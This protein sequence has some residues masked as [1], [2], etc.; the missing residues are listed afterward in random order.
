MKRPMKPRYGYSYGWR[1]RG[2]KQ[3]P[4]ENLERAL[5]KKIMVPA[6]TREEIYKV[7]NTETG[8][9]W[10]GRAD[11]TKF[12]DDEGVSFGSREEAAKAVAK[13]LGKAT[14]GEF[15]MTRLAVRIREIQKWEIVQVKITIRFT[16]NRSLVDTTEYQVLAALLK[17]NRTVGAAF[18]RHVDKFES[19]EIQS[20]VHLDDYSSN[21]EEYLEDIPKDQYFKHRTV[22]AFKDVKYGLMLKLS[23]PK[24]NSVIDVKKIREAVSAGL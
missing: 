19:H 13:L 17:E 16:D 6:S 20:I 11:H 9:Y 18:Q 10:T 3:V 1:A 24:V 15:S 2:R 4:S 21:L 22:L 5:Q 7:R 8:F 14:D 23:L 12:Y